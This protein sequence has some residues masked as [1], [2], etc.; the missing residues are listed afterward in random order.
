ML[1]GLATVVE[2]VGAGA[3]GFFE[4]VGADRKVMETAFVRDD[5]CRLLFGLSFQRGLH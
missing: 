5:L 4:G 1:A 2:D 3:A